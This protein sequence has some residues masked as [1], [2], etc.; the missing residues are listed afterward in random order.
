MGSIKHKKKTIFTMDIETKDVDF[1]T[2]DD[3][4]TSDDLKP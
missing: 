1:I 4:R 2:N 3:R